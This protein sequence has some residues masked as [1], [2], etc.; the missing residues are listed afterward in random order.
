MFVVT[1]AEYNFVQRVATA[2]AIRK[3]T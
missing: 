1:Q 3:R 2:T